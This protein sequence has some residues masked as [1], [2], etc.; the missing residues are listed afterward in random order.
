MRMTVSSVLVD[1]QRRALS[2]YTGPLGLL[3]KNDIP[4]GSHSWLTVVSPEDP[5]GH[6]LLLEPDEHPAAKQFKAA[7]MTDGI[8][9]ISFTCA[10]VGHEHERLVAAGLRFT[11][12]PTVM[13][14]VTTAVFDD[15]CGNLVQL[16]SHNAVTEAG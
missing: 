1:D 14:P 13:G 8:P 16:V 6:E 2:V 10:D 3:K 12:P 11:Q 4:L 7:L 9:L 15:T 5:D